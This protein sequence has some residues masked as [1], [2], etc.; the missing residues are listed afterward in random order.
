M[1]QLSTLPHKVRLLQNQ[2]IPMSDGTR[3]ATRIWLPEEAAQQPVPAILEYIPYR[4][5][6]RYSDSRRNVARLFFW[7]W[8][9]LYQ[10]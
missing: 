3:L 4:K 9:C 2:W 10:G 6:R 7:A 5:T 8:V 1:T